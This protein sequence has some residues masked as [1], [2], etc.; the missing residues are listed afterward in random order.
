MLCRKSFAETLKAG[1]EK[2]R[3]NPQACI[4]TFS[5]SQM[6]ETGISERKK[7]KTAIP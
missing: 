5:F 2:G 1:G 6:L 3:Q 4:Y 7:N